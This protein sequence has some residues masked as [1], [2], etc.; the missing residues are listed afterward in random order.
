MFNTIN[1]GGR[2]GDDKRSSMRRSEDSALNCTIRT[3]KFPKLP[4]PSPLEEQPPEPSALKLTLQGLN[5]TQLRRSL[6][7]TAMK[8]LNPSRKPLPRPNTL[9]TRKD[10]PGDQPQAPQNYVHLRANINIINHDAEKKNKKVRRLLN[11][12]VELTNKFQR[13]NGRDL[14]M[15]LT[16]LVKSP[17]T[18]NTAMK[19]ADAESVESYVSTG[20]RNTRNTLNVQNLNNDSAGTLGE[21]TKEVTAA[22]F[23]KSA[24]AR[25]LD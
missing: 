14:Y 16:G 1:A 11:K 19:T 9:F 6:L 10:F 4:G 8:N 20:M 23:R 15:G 13:E 3:L 22:S 7:I 17:R 24:E 12:S 5:L 25:T 21:A 18:R 2:L